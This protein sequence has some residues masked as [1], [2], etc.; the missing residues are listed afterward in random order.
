M[1][2]FARV[3]AGLE[4]VAWRD[5]ARLTGAALDGFGHRRIDFIY[6]GAPSDL[7]AL[8]SV[9]DVYVF[10]TQ[11]D[12]F[13]HTRPSLSAFQQFRGVDFSP[14]LETISQVRPLGDKPTYGVTASFL[15]KRNY[16][17]Y[18]IEDK[19]HTVLYEKL[20]WR[21]VA[22][23][24]DENDAHDLDLRVLMEDDWALIG[25]RLGETPLHRRPYK[26]VSLPGSLK[27]PVAYALCLL[28]DLQ[29]TDRLLDITCGAG[30][31][32]VEASGL[33]TNG[34]LAGIDLDPA[35]V[36]MAHQNAL[37]ADL[38]AEVVASLDDLFTSGAGSLRLLTGDSTALAMPGGSVDA[39]IANPPWGRQVA[40]GADMTDL[41][42]GLL[43][44]VDHVL[45]E[46]GRA[47][48]LTDQADAL[49]AALMA[50]PRLSVESPQT[51]SLF[52]SHP[53]I[54]VLRRG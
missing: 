33:I 14:A 36:E 30:T 22:N 54:T 26:S 35:A 31:I 18:D 42:T 28:A 25:L 16:S 38:R 12:E 9:D 34:A 5:I 39:V 7:L 32:L 27:A 41:Y 6:D 10:V 48:L 50:H 24:P 37:A 15:G 2:Y 43:R 23:R 47:V 52:G 8:K 13:N 1:N 19:I 21:F 45:T 17:R 51:I 20:P 46:G 40:A 4:S 49:S 3:T 44:T 29:P 11:L 53:V